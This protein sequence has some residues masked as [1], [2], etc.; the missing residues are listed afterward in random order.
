MYV[1]YETVIKTPY[2]FVAENSKG[3]FSEGNEVI[4][5]SS[6]ET[7][8]DI[9]RA[10]FV[11]SKGFLL[12]G[13]LNIIKGNGEINPNFLAL[14]LSHGSSKK[15]LS[16]LAQGKTIVHIHKSDLEGLKIDIPSINE[17]IG[18]CHV[19]NSLD[20]LITLHQRKQYIKLTKP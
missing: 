10:S 17:Q 9:S 15:K 7:A 14:T 4:V 12:G 6:G 19:F 3:K 16:N 1:K 8:E 13:D 2:T 11:S 5:P 20:S 18:I